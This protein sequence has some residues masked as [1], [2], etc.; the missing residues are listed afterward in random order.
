[1]LDKRIREADNI[2]MQIVL[3]GEAIYWC[4]GV[5][6]IIETKKFD[7]FKYILN[8]FNNSISQFSS[9]QI[10]PCEAVHRELYAKLILWMIFTRD[11]TNSN[12]FD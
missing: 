4:R 12:L 5:T 3:L 10:N 1:M 6:K 2:P 9:Y 8:Y 7:D 11:V